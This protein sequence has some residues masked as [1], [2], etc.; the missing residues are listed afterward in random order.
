[1]GKHTRIIY[2]LEDPE[3]GNITAV[4]N[5]LRLLPAGLDPFAP[6]IELVPNPTWELNDWN[7]KDN[8]G[9]GWIRKDRLRDLFN[10]NCDR[11]SLTRA[12][13]AKICGVTRGTMYKYCRGTLPVPEAV[14]QTVER[15]T[16]TR[17]A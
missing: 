16:K 8:D 5:S 12:D 15:L 1:M 11:T 10:G 7:G 3:T 13:L 14:W 6:V 4:Y 9:C 17:N 2:G